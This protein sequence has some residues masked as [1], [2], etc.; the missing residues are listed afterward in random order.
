MSELSSEISEYPVNISSRHLAYL[1]VE[2]KALKEELAIYK[3]IVDK[4]LKKST[5]RGLLIHQKIHEL[6]PTVKFFCDK[7]ALRKC[8]SEDEVKRKEYERY[9]KLITGRDKSIEPS[10]SDYV[11]IGNELDKLSS[12]TKDTLLTIF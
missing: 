11:N 7:K 1:K 9:T 2:N 12:F 4:K 8:L 3:D 10:Q 5:E 6:F